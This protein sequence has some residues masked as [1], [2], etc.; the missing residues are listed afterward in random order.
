MSLAMRPPLLEHCSRVR[1]SCGLALHV[2]N[3][4]HHPVADDRERKVANVLMRP[5]DRVEVLDTVPD[6]GQGEL[7]PPTCAVLSPREALRLRATCPAATVH[8][9]HRGQF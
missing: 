6:G 2:P 7:A 4:L 3:V 9:H 5:Q 8:L 1:G